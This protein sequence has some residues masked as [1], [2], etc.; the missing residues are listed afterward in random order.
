MEMHK[1]SQPPQGVETRTAQIEFR[2]D[3]ESRTATGYAAMFN[4]DSGDLG[5]FTESIA[6]GAFEAALKKSDVR[7]LFNHNPDLVL[8]RTASGTLKL[9]TDGVGLRYTFDIP[10][11]SYGNDFA[12]ML[13]RG[14][15]SQSS[16]GF[17]VERDAWE[18]AS[19]E[20]AAGSKYPKMKRTILE[21]RELFDVS[22]VTYPAYPD[23][24]VALRSMPGG[25]TGEILNNENEEARLIQA[26]HLKR[27]IR[28][29]EMEA[30]I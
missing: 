24:T 10:N 2:A 4:L 17:T 11:T 18:S 16:F 8:A 14:D 7:A 22:P 3:G 19:E 30:S 29:R 15:V 6:P 27:N 1:Y 26:D 25:D 20:K 23:T 21:V 28:L 13:K 9:E 12:E 5:G